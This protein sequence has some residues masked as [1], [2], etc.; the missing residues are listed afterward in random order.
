MLAFE[1][2]R[3]THSTAVPH[4]VH[5]NCQCLGSA[6]SLQSY[7]LKK[8]VN[9]H[10]DIKKQQAL[11]QSLQLELVQARTQLGKRKNGEPKVTP[12]TQQS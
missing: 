5:P 1:P 10:A 3:T 7:A 2:A 6:I 4:E 8:A 12:T 11:I 9:A